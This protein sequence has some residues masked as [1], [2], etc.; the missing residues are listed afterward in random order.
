MLLQSLARLHS[1][2]L[3]SPEV[4]QEQLASSQ[5]D[6]SW[7]QLQQPAAAERHLGEIVR[8]QLQYDE[9]FKQVSHL[10]QQLANI[11]EL[12]DPT[13]TEFDKDRMLLIREKEQLLRE[14]R[15]LRLD[16]RPQP[17]AEEIHSRILQLE[18]DLVQAMHQSNTQITER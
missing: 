11:E 18:Q 10:Q 13:Q 6:L 14:L 15:G 16:G 1:S 17:E 9:A 4:S 2:K 12:M 7:P 8:M 5:T 3:E